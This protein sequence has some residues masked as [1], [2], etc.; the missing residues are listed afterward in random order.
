MPLNRHYLGELRP[1][2]ELFALL[3]LEQTIKREMR[4]NHD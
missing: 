3:P 4:K 2:P 1:S